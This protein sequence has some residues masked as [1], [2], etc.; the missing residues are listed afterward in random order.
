MP[1]KQ[2][3][4]TLITGADKGIGFETAMELGR[5]GQHILVGSRDKSREFRA[6][7]RLHQQRIKS[8]LMILDVTSAVSIRAVADR[9]RNQ[10]GYLNILINNAGVAF[11]HHESA[12]TMSIETIRRDFDVNFFGLIQVTQAMVPLLLKAD[13]AKIINVSSNMGSLDLASDPTSQF[14]N[15][16]SLG[17]Q[18]SKAAVNSATITFSKTLAH[19]GIT[20]NAVNP[21]YTATDFGGRFG[22]TQTVQQGAARIVSLARDLDSEVTGTF[23]ENAGKLPW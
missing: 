7:K 17:Y 2:S 16:S 20:V 1:E 14:Y 19:V 5:L 4:L 10:F 6:V 18:A 15:V 9:I 13:H 22:G 11:D 21:G 8:D 3:V 12:L 23:S